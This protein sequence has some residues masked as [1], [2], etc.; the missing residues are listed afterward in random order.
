MGKRRTV[1]PSSA[2]KF[3]G[4]RLSDAEREEIGRAALNAGVALATFIRDA[5]L[6]LAGVAEAEERLARARRERTALLMDVG[7]VADQVELE[8][9]HR[10]TVYTRA[11]YLD[12]LRGGALPTGGFMHDPARYRR[13]AGR[14]ASGFLW[15]SNVNDAT[16]GGSASPASRPPSGPPA[17]L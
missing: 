7:S 16:A 1:E 12:R 15:S 14:V 10:V 17:S 6:A 11:E 13:H 2:R 4:I 3:V 8:P 5:A 9:G